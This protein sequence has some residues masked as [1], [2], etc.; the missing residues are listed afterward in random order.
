[1]L[2]IFLVRMPINENKT[3]K[4]NG[5]F[6]KI[7][8]QNAVFPATATAGIFVRFLNDFVSRN[9]GTS[10]LSNVKYFRISS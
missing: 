6:S 7:K 1:M 5:A 10:S 2:V 4:E 3:H 8:H 9:F